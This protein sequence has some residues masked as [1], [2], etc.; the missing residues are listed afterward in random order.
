MTFFIKLILLFLVLTGPSAAQVPA[1]ED[2]S[3]GTSG[4]PLPRFAAL[5]TDEINLRTG[6]GTRYPIEWIYVREGLPL[7]ITAEFEIWRRVRDWEGSEGWLHKSALTGKRTL[8]VTGGTRTVYE[9]TDETSAPKARVEQGA[10]GSLLG[11]EASWCQVKFGD[12]NGYMPK[13]SFWGVYNNETF[14]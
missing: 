5:H 12:I 1:N 8:I 10:I 3:K 2:A 6:P 9:D 7:E 13:T 4:L 11:C 14:N